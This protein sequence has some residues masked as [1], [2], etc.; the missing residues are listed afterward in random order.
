MTVGRNGSGT[1]IATFNSMSRRINLSPIAIS[2]PVNWIISHADSL[3]VCLPCICDCVTDTAFDCAV[4]EISC[5]FWQRGPIIDGSDAIF[6]WDNLPVVSVYAD[7]RTCLL[8]CGRLSSNLSFVTQTAARKRNF[9]ITGMLGGQ[10]WIRRYR[11]M[12]P[13][14]GDNIIPRESVGKFIGNRRKS[15]A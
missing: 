3:L 13:S 7:C 4:G 6:C 9:P 11:V 8:S 1:R 15:D 2:P 14:S 5:R 12:R 10:E